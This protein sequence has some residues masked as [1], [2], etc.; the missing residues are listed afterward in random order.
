[1]K[2][3][4]I[5]SRYFPEE[6][7]NHNQE[8]YVVLTKMLHEFFNFE[9]LFDAGCRDGKLIEELKKFNPNTKLKGCDYF[10]WALDAADDSVKDSIYQFD[11]RDQI[12]EEKHDLVTCFEVAEHI[13]VD[14][15]DIFLENLRSVTGKYMVITWS[16]SG[17]ENQREFDTHLQHL[18][19]LQRHQVIEKVQKY[20]NYEETLTNEFLQRSLYEPHFLWYWRK[21]LTVWSP[22]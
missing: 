6:E 3:I 15:C 1:M 4:D 12:N 13:D 21:S 2:K 20:F 22:K 17:G 14:Y 8:P 10:Q 11:L 19:P 7:L 5:D 9:S 18:N 16:D